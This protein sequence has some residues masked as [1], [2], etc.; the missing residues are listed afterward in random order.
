[1]GSNKRIEIKLAATGSTLQ[2]LKKNVNSDRIII[3]VFIYIDR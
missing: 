2:S 3:I 1:M